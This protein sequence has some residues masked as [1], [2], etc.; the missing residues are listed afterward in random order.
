[1][2]TSANEPALPICPGV[3]DEG[4]IGNG[5]LIPVTVGGTWTTLKQSTTW[6]VYGASQTSSLGVGLSNPF[7]GG[8][9]TESGTFSIT[10]GLEETYKKYTGNLSRQ[11][12]TDFVY[13]LYDQCGFEMIQPKEWAGGKIYKDVFALKHLTLCVPEGPGTSKVSKGTAATFKAGVSIAQDIGIDLSAQTGYSTSAELFFKVNGNGTHAKLCGTT[14][15][16]GSPS[17]GSLQLEP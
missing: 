4:P 6:M 12:R 8:T 2:A 14:G 17:P 9:V 1:M 10:S 11:Y 7:E 15:Y 16:P 5:A 13:E 3:I